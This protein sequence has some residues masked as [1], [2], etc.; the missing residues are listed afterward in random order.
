MP[1]RVMQRT[2]VSEN[3]GAGSKVW[4]SLK[5]IVVLLCLAWPNSVTVSL[6]ELGT[7]QR[8]AIRDPSKIG[9]KT[10]VSRVC[11]I[12]SQSLFI[13][14]E[15]RTSWVSVGASTTSLDVSGTI[16]LDPSPKKHV[17]F[18]SFDIQ[19]I[20]A[21]EGQS[22][23]HDEINRLF[24]NSS[25]GNEEETNELDELERTRRANDARYK[26]GRIHEQRTQRR[27][28]RR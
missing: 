14:P 5:S 24:L 11:S 26:G 22:M 15:E 21:L 13:A 23:L 27:E 6:R 9:P 19:P 4:E 18:I 1:V 25:F 3:H 2:V 20:M 12:L 17:Q 7:N 10:D 28:E 16:S 8:M